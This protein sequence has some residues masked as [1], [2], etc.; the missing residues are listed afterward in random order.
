[1][2]NI[3][4]QIESNIKA[5]DDEYKEITEQIN[6]LTTRATYLKGCYDFAQTMLLTLNEPP[7][8]AK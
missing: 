8:K 1:M 2:E 5:F 4:K 3:R 7:K 6:T